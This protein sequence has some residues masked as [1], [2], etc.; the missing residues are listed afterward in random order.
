MITLN[1]N[2]TVHRLD[3]DPAMPLLWAV[4]DHIGLT[5]TK[6]GCGIAECGAC[7]LLL[8]GA[9]VRS[10]AVPLA[11]ADGRKITTIERLDD[12]AGRAVQ[13]AWTELDVVQC[14]FC[15]SGQI[16][17]AT[18]LLRDNHSPSDADIDRALSGVLC[19]CATYARIRAAIKRAAA[20]LA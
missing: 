8:D 6:Y 20:E 14:G 9:P 5:G 4:R 13:K 7:T 12:D 15:Q 3:L 11:A 18:A 1:V 17:S 10:C 2:G 16:L 19:R